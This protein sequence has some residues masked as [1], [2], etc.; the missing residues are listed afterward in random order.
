MDSF[1]F[2]FTLFGLVLGLALT[3]VLGGFA[4]AVKRHG[5]ARLGLLTPVV[6]LF[7]LYEITDFWMDAWDVRA[8]VP[9]G[10]PTL[11]I[12]VVITGLYFFAAVLVWPEEGDAAWEDL[13]GWMLA[14]KRQVLLSVFASNLVT[15]T[16]LSSIAASEIPPTLLAVGWMASYFGLILA[17]ALVP[18]RRLTLAALALLLTMYGSGL[19]MDLLGLRG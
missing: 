18:G 13:D 10:M 8:Q 2:I 6:S 16:A 3:E 5:P 19:A 9:I 11:L 1:E 14:H 15:V 17:A 4:R 12:S 7:M